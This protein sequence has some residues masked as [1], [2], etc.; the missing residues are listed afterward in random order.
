MQQQRNNL[1]PSSI[2]RALLIFLL[3]LTPMKF[4]LPRSYKATIDCW[5]QILV[6]SFCSLIV[7]LA[8]LGN[9]THSSVDGPIN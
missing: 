6:D 4:W 9:C 3:R 2:G 1:L 8:E 7:S 5:I